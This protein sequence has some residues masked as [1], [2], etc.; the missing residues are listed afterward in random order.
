MGSR[1]IVTR[2]LNGIAARW[3]CAGMQ[4]QIDYMTMKAPH[5]VYAPLHAQAQA[6]GAELWVNIR[7]HEHRYA[8]GQPMGIPGE[9]SVWVLDEGLECRVDHAA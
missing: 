9:P 2:W 6:N 8:H 5:G 7:T 4:S 3:Q 1:H